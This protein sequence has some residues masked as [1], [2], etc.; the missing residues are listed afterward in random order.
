M[1]EINIVLQW[2]TAQEDFILYAY[3]LWKF[4]LCIGEEF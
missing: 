1:M 2:L 4:Q 3:L